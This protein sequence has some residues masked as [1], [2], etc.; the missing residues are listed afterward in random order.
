MNEGF[1]F[2]VSGP[3]VLADTSSLTGFYWIGL[4]VGWGLLI[5]STVFGGD[6]DSD[7]DADF[8]ADFDV[9][10]DAGVEMDADVEGAHAH[11]AEGALSLASW[12][13]VRFL[14]YFA[15]MF[16]LIGTV[17]TYMSDM[18]TTTILVL[19]LLGGVLVGQMAHQVFRY[20]KRSS[21]DSATTLKDYLNKPARVTIAIKP[22]ARGE[23]AI[24]IGDSERF[25]AAIAKR[26]DDTFEV[27]QSVGVVGFRAGTALVVSQKEHE[28][29]SEP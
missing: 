17:L 18:G 26:E 29:L 12:F 5:I 28:F 25:V 2:H 10:A 13:S 19:A 23:V 9:D 27:G 7:I 16:G 15:A 6:A 22:P 20:F 4:I 8:D 3:A 1:L 11:A 21:S 24:R 14:I